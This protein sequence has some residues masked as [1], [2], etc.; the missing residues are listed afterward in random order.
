VKKLRLQL[1]ALDSAK[2][3]RD[4]D[5]PGW[6]LHA[7]RGSIPPRW[8]LTIDRNWRLTFEFVE[9]N[10]HQLNYEDYH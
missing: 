10:A 2:T 3:V 9:G 7:L 8:S 4:V 5:L 1:G 6:R